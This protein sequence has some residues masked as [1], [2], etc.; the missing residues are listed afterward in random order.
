MDV[1]VWTYGVYLLV[2]VAL[3]VWVGKTLHRNGRLFLVDAMRGNDQL[4]DPVNHPLL[5]G[6]YLINVGFV[7]L[8]LRFG[9]KAADVQG[10][11]EYL[12]TKIG[13][14]L[15]VLGMMHFFNLFVLSR[16][17]RRALRPELPAAVLPVEPHGE[18]GYL[19]KLRT[20]AVPVDEDR[21]R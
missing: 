14:V 4:A 10:A 16:M 7:S 9:P 20:M 12:S 19:G 18:R 21:R 6:F 5:V 1:M 11:V 8:A 15:L 2:S 3:T 17:R 13:I